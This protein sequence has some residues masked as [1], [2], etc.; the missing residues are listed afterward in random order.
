MSKKGPFEE[1]FGDF[2]IFLYGMPQGPFD[3]SPPLL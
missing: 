3:S 2:W 1:N